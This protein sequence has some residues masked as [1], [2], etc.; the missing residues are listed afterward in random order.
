MV[1]G[2]IL[3]MALGALLLFIGLSTAGLASV[4]SLLMLSAGAAFFWIGLGITLA[5]T[6]V[7]AIE[8]AA[9][10]TASAIAA[11]EA[12]TRTGVESLWKQLDAVR[13]LQGGA[14]PMERPL[15]VGA[16]AMPEPPP[17]PRISGGAAGLMGYCPGCR[18]LRGLSTIKCV[19]CGNTERAVEG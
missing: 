12:T 9:D 14:P 11:L 1:V 15:T 6:I 7:N 16:V 13:Q 5:G 4:G 8:R 10:R 3:L 2:G 18:K 19:Y 17:L